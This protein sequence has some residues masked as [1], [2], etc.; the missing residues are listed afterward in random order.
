MKSN[1]FGTQISHGYFQLENKNVCTANI[2]ESVMFW[3]FFLFY[4]LYYSEFDF[5]CGCMYCKLK[6]IESRTCLN[7][8]Q[9]SVWLFP[10]CMCV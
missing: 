6:G 8:C 10:A 4:F 3:G 2:F 7:R 1:T 9:N 5:S